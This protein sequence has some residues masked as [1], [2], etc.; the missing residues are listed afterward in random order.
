MGIKITGEFDL[1]YRFI[2]ETSQNIFLTGRAGTGKTTFLKYLRDN[3]QKQSVVAAPTGVAA[4]NAQGVTLHSLF[5]LPL[6]IIVPDSLPVNSHGGKVK[7]HPLLS[8][9]R[10]NKAKLDLLRN[11]DLLIIDEASM[12]A[13]YI[14]DAVDTILRYI[15]RK[16]YYPFGGVQVLF[17]GDLHQLPPVVKADDWMI[18]QKFYNS[19]FFFDSLVLRDNL[20]VIIELKEIFRQKD[21]G[22]IEILNGIRDNNI[23]EE[24]FR[25]LNSRLKRFFAPENNE[26][27]ITLTTH[28][29][30]SDEIN[31]QRL[32]NIKAPEYIYKA[33]ISDEFPENSYPAD[34][35]LKLKVGAQVMFLKND[36][37]GRRY[38]NGK[39]G[40][41]TDLEEDC[42]KVMCK[43][44]FDVIKVTKS[45][46]QNVRYKV[47]SDTK[48]ITQQILGTFTQY[49]L[50]LAWAI[51]IHK[52]QGLTFDKVIIDAE[53]AFAKGQVYVALSRCTSL[54]GLILKSPV[55]RNSLGAHKD[56][57]EWQNNNLNKNLPQLFNESRQKYI[58]D[59]LLNI[60][61]WKN[62]Q[63]ELKDFK[64]F[65]EENRE[66][67]NSSSVTWLDD[68]SKRHKELNDVSEKFRQTIIK[69]SRNNSHVETNQ[70]LQKRIRDGAEYFFNA[71]S[72]WRETFLNH[73]L[74]VETKRIAGDMDDQISQIN[75]ILEDILEKIDFC[76][77]G[78]ILNDYLK[79][80]KSHVKRI[81]EIRSTYSRRKKNTVLETVKM[82]RKF[83]DIQ[84]VAG[85]RDLTIGTIESHL[86]KAIQ[87]DLLQI[88]EVISLNEVME[89]TEYFPEELEDIRLSSIKENAPSEISYGKLRMVLAMLR[90]EYT[91]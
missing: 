2:T 70:V 23:S 86:A 18:L 34:K 26:E 12:V 81:K 65:Y 22:F 64:D 1:A 60:F 31:R 4:I 71:L 58:T 89:I 32:K 82:F 52:S 45:E 79:R 5:Q 76:K 7:N 39:I 16:P 54:E 75:V 69:L 19:V 49:P 44:D 6:G 78:F 3:S 55:H 9:I 20:P 48:E 80:N 47:N 41:V 67:I 35:Y 11:M 53:R 10:Y 15:R 62:W 13:S 61:T 57:K 68:L 27:Y 33:D 17:I 28:N 90:K 83:R 51:T 43:D 87:Q 74:A 50:R 88:D 37:E 29:D 21:S 66:K 85:E 40:T 14:V 25:I 42:I 38:F 91:D 36:N 30:Q 73:P 72:V 59:E 46:W 24:N 8:K 63:Y 77:E 84:Q 56:F